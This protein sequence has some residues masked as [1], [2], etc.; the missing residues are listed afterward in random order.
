[1]SSRF[2]GTAVNVSGCVLANSFND[3]Q[4]PVAVPITNLLFKA[5]TEEVMRSTSPVNASKAITALAEECSIRYSKSLARNISE[6]DIGTIP[7]FRQPRKTKYASGRRGVMTN[8]RS[9]F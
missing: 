9:P 4:L 3:V 2:V 7:A 1:M 5:S 6:Q 8:T